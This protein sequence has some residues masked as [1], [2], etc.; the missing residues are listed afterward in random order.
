MNLFVI[1]G[2]SY[3]GLGWLQGF[4]GHDKAHMHFSQSGLIWAKF[5][6]G[7]SVIFVYKLSLGGLRF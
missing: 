2:L 1:L 6:K 3:L 5:E 4:V 7:A